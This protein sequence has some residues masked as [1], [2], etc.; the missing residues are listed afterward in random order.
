[1]HMTSIDWTIFIGVTA[2]IFFLGAI[3]KQFFGFFCF[4]MVM[5]SVGLYIVLLVE[6]LG[7]VSDTL[8]ILLFLGIFPYGILICRFFYRLFCSHYSRKVERSIGQDSVVSASEKAPEPQINVTVEIPGSS[9][10]MFFDGKGFLRSYGDCYFDSK[11][12][13]RSPEDM[14]FDGKGYL[15]SP[16]DVFFD[17]KGYLRSPGDMFFDGEGYLR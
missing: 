5:V 3:T 8:S 16:G 7:E 1:M 11:G 17:S 4:Y 15:R 9:N 2:L 10:R 12:Y 13:L 14:F 6:L